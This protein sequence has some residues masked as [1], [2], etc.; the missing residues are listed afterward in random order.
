MQKNDIICAKCTAIGGNYYML[1]IYI[2][3]KCYNFRM[4]SRKPDA[5]CF[6]CGST[7]D[8]CNVSYVDFMNMTEEDRNR[9]KEDYKNRIMTYK[10]KLETVFIDKK[11][12]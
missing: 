11:T 5:I 9:F 4:V 7:L 6:H 10:E 1:R 2:C 12:K 3:P 8:R